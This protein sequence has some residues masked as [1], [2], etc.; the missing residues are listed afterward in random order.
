MAESPSRNASTPAAQKSA[1]REVNRPV[2]DLFNESTQREERSRLLGKITEYLFVSIFVMTLVAY[3]WAL[4][5]F[6]WTPRPLVFAALGI[7]LVSYALVRV[8]FL[9]RRL[10]GLHLQQNAAQ[11][12]KSSVENLSEF[13][14]FVFHNIR[15]GTGWDLG[16]VIVGPPGAFTL[17]A[18]FATRNGRFG[19]CLDHLDRHTLHL[20]GREPLA[21]PLGHARRSAFALYSLLAT[22]NLETIPVQPI[23][24][25]PGW[26]LGKQPPGEERDVWVVNEQGLASELTHLPKLLE[27]KDLIGVCTL[28]ERHAGK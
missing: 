10:H 24:I 23:L 2:I 21:D 22:A 20:A 1:W 6:Q 15:D 28:L 13:G 26:P 4:W 14:Y 11:N 9:W 17:T 25:F 27:P 7:P 19:E 16:S 12:L 3:E 8:A 18:R 5:F